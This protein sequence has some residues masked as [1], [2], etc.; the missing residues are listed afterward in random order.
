VSGWA[1][2]SAKLSDMPG[3]PGPV[4][5]EHERFRNRADAGRALAQRLMRYARRSDTLVLGLPRGGVVVAGEVAVAL[6]LPL[7]LW[8]V[9]KLG[10]PEQ[11]ELALGAISSHD[12]VFVDEP[13]VRSLGLAV[14][15]VQGI[16]ERE[17]RE[18]A[19]RECVYRRGRPA[20]RIAGQTLLVVDDGVATGSTM[21]AA[22]VALRSLSPEHI[23]VAVPVASREARSELAALADECVC[24]VCP[25]PFHA[26]GAW[27][28]DFAE[29]SDDEVIAWLDRAQL[30]DPGTS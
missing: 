20:P 21:R 12:V 22:L 5:D 11:P 28:D 9:R 29:T 4:S 23:V 18:L 10:A 7:D 26:V 6:G 19:R 30:A 1:G 16:V 14:H 17:R 2:V 24:L 8:V 3:Y 27:Y 15:T 13:L 25:E